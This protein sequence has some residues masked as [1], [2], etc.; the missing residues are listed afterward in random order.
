MEVGDN[1]IVFQDKCL[2]KI[3]FILLPKT[4]QKQFSL[5]LRKGGGMPEE[6]PAVE[7]DENSN[8][9]SSQSYEQ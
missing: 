4:V 7:E 2:Q 1:T 3:L 5:L 8:R 9:Y 6:K